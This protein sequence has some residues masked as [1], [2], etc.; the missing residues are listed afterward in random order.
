MIHHGWDL[1]DWQRQRCSLSN[2]VRYEVVAYFSKRLH[3]YFHRC[4]PQTHLRC[5]SKTWRNLFP[6]TYKYKRGEI[7]E[8]FLSCSLKILIEWSAI[9]RKSLTSSNSSSSYSS[10]P[11]GSSSSGFFFSPSS[12]SELPSFSFCSRVWMQT[13]RCWFSKQWIFYPLTFLSVENVFLKTFQRHFSTRW[14]QNTCNK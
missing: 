13:H 5:Q 6:V 4:H 10:S 1:Q 9:N 12:S 11:S 8:Q 2:R 14:N 3:P 7:K